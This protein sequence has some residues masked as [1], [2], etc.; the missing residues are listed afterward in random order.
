MAA[1]W[2][3]GKSDGC[4]ALSLPPAFARSCRRKAIHLPAF[5]RTIAVARVP[6]AFKGGTTKAVLQSETLEYALA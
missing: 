1:S 4:R 5:L 3:A 6:I 2:A